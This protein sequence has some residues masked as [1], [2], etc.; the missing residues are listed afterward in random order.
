MTLEEQLKDEW[1]KH[2]LSHQTQ[3]ADNFKEY[4]ADYWLSKLQ[5]ILQERADAIR[6]EKVEQ[7]EAKFADDPDNKLSEGYSIG[8]NQALETAALLVEEAIS[9]K[10]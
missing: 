8:Y 7:D 2:N 10:E 4:V 1:Y 5:M 6:G 3:T 9:S